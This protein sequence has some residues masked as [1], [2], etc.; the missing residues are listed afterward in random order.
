MKRNAV[1]P[2]TL[3]ILVGG[4]GLPV[5]HNG[6][7]GIGVLLGP[8][9]GYLAGFIPAALVT[10]FVYE[11]PSNLFHIVGLAAASSIILFI[12]TVWLI[13]S[14]GMAP[15]AGLI[16][17]LVVFLPG[18]AVKTYAAYRIAQHLP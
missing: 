4:A 7:S 13:L 10:G 1:I 16:A 3:Y 12:G 5:F 17:G 2:V 8:T 15:A 18:D 11:H 9:G 6:I 14:T